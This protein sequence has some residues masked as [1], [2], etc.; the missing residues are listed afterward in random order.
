MISDID[1][2]TDFMLALTNLSLL[3]KQRSTHTFI[4]K[5]TTSRSDVYAYIQVT[6]M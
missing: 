6:G 3:L 5:V 2:M 1:G 4:M